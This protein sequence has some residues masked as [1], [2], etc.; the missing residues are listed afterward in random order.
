MDYQKQKYSTGSSLLF[1]GSSVFAT[2]L[3]NSANNFAPLHLLQNILGTDELFAAKGAQDN[4]VQASI[5]LASLLELDLVRSKLHSS[6]SSLVL[7]NY[8]V[9][10]SR[11]HSSFRLEFL[12]LSLSVVYPQSPSRLRSDDEIVIE[13]EQ[14]QE[15]ESN[16]H[17]T[18]VMSSYPEP[19]RAHELSS[20]FPSLSWHLSYASG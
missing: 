9:E 7:F 5:S 11:A 12:S 1:C 8:I 6:L 13:E 19:S 4:I 2:H 20:F 10:Q 17:P 14:E 18:T 3:K 16:L 15:Q